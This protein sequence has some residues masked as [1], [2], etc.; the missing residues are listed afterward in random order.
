MTRFHAAVLALALACGAAH[1]QVVVSKTSGAK[2]GLDLSGLAGSGEAGQAFRSVL[3]SDL[4][5]SGWF[6]KTPAA[7]AAYLVRGSA[8]GGLSAQVQVQDAMG[9]QKLGRAYSGTAAEARKLAHVAANEIIFALTGR[10]GMYSGRIA[11]IG[12]RT[13][14]KELY[15]C[16][17]DGQ[18]MRQITHDN[19]VSLGPYWGPGGRLISYTSYLKGYPDPYI[20]EPATGSRRRV[21]ATSRLNA[22]GGIS[23]DGNQI[24]L[25]LSQGNP[26]LFVSDLSGAGRVQLTRTPKGDEAAPCWSPDG[27]QIAYMMGQSGSVQIYR[28]DRGG[29]APT[30]LTTQGSNNCAPDWGPNGLITYAG[31]TGGKFHI[32]IVHPETRQARQ[33]T[34]D[35]ADYEDPTWAPDG[36]HILCARSVNY[37]SQLYVVDTAE[38]ADPPFPLTDLAGDWYSPTWSR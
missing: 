28:I 8:A 32:W 30:R 4:F 5:R 15:V 38:P 1:A 19:V 2:M 22:A 17:C 33:I 35:F 10:K 7:S 13:G 23:P 20:V 21:T 24:A 37:H 29:G 6:V 26:E 11:V 27:R 14:K 18:N 36:R 34:K 12:N 3:E 16:D 31:L 25:I 9:V